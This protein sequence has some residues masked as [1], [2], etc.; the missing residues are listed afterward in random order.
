MAL[1]QFKNDTQNMHTYKGI[2]TH[3]R[4]THSVTSRFGNTAR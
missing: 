4:H 2:F 1:D 3:T